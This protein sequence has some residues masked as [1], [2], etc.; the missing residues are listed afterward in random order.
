[1]LLRGRVALQRCAF[2]TAA[3]A[4]GSGGWSRNSRPNADVWSLFSGRTGSVPGGYIG[5]AKRAGERFGATHAQ[6]RRHPRETQD[7]APGR[8]HEERES[9]VATVTPYLSQWPATLESASGESW[10]RLART[11]A[12][13]RHPSRAAWLAPR[14]FVPTR[15]GRPH[16]DAEDHPYRGRPSGRATRRSR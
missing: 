3:S 5:S 8:P 10:G 7:G 11:I 15:G 13:T 6:P 2:G 16:R 1:M 9:A 14:S 4:D 12:S